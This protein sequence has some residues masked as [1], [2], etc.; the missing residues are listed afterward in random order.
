MIPYP[1]TNVGYV[2]KSVGIGPRDRGIRLWDYGR[3]SAVGDV[4]MY[5]ASVSY[6]INRCNLLELCM[7]I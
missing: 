2:I 6:G 3:Q 4:H 1:Y 7:S 5:I